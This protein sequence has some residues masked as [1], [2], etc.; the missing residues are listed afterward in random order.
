MIVIQFLHHGIS[1]VLFVEAE[2]EDIPIS[3][4]AFATLVIECDKPVVHKCRGDQLIV[5]MEELKTWYND[6]WEG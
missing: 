2:I 1:S 3:M 6:I 5:S 4:R